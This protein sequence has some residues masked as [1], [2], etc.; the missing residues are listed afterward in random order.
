MK[1][2]S[3]G[4]E[5]CALTVA[6]EEAPADRSTAVERLPSGVGVPLTLCEPSE[7]PLVFPEKAEIIGAITFSAIQVP[8]AEAETR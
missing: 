6:P 5:T 7:S 8:A 2:S 4:K 3:A 1:Q